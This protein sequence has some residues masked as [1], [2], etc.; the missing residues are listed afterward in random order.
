[1]NPVAFDE[2]LRRLVKAGDSK[3]PDGLLSGKAQV[4]ILEA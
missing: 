1:M 3:M 2:I 4:A